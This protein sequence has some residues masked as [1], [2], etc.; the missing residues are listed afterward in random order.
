MVENAAAQELSYSIHFPPGA[1]EGVRNLPDSIDPNHY[2][3]YREIRNLAVP[4]KGWEAFRA[5]FD[6]LEYPQEAKKRKLQSVMTVAY[7]IDENGTVDSVYIQSVEHYGPFT[8]CE[9][10]EAIMLDYIKHVQ[11]SPG[12]IGETPVKTKDYVDVEFRIRDPKKIP[13]PFGY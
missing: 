7:K 5:Y 4:T 13:G 11:W 10:C 3:T 6:T 8:K 1:R 2:Y 9:P 12:R